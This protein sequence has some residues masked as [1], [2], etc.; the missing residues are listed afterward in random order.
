MAILHG[1]ETASD[2]IHG[3]KYKKAQSE[4][5]RKPRGKIC[6]NNLTINQIINKLALSSEHENEIAKELWPRL[7]SELG[8]LNLDPYQFETNNDI[9]KWKCEYDFGDKRKLITFGQFSNVVSESRNN[10]RTTPHS[11]LR[12]TKEKTG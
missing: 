6:D 12:V 1:K 3:Q 9:T 10:F 11:G 4:K 2:I 7:Y 8:D 5:T